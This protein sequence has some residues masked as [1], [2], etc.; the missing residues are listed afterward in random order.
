M[1]VLGSHAITG[2][3]DGHL[4]KLQRAVVGGR[5][6]T[7]LREALERGVFEVPFHHGA[8]AIQLSLAGL[9]PLNASSL[10]Q[11]A[12]SH[13]GPRQ[14]RVC[15]SVQPISRNGVLEGAF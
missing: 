11:V 4:G 9:V 15:P 7:V 6:S 2:T 1:A 3:G 8:K 10:E 13:L 5:K 14:R 12:P